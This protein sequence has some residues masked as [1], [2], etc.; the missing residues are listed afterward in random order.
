MNILFQVV[1]Y[2]EG[3]AVLWNWKS[4]DRGLINSIALLYIWWFIMI[5]HFLHYIS[6][7]RDVKCPFAEEIVYTIKERQYFEQI[8][9]S[10]NYASKLLL[11]LLV[12]EKE[13][14]ARLG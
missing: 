8:E 9:K 13:L 6:P 5:W 12:D 1:S 14:M 10:Y 4:A 2:F 7:G 11:N 3:R